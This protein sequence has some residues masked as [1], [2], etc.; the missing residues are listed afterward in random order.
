MR[1]GHQESKPRHWLWRGCRNC[2]TSWN[3]SPANSEIAAR[4]QDRPVLVTVDLRPEPGVGDPV[5]ALDPSCVL[6]EDA[7][8]RSYGLRCH[9]PFLS[10]RRPA[11]ETP[12]DDITK[13]VQEGF[14]AIRERKAAGGPGWGE[15]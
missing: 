14:A 11:N 5:Y 1:G 7:R 6:P 15:P 3:D 10:R 2:K 9:P 4:K 13:S 12:D 8:C